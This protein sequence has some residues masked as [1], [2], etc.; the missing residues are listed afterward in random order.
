MHEGAQEG[1]MLLG[2]WREELRLH[3]ETR[4]DMANRGLDLRLRN[5]IDYPIIKCT[6]T[7]LSVYGVQHA[8]RGL[9]LLRSPPSQI[10]R[11]DGHRLIIISRHVLIHVL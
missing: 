5:L 6:L 1:A 9:S 10:L 11:V 7:F 3:L 4:A 8:F 2:A